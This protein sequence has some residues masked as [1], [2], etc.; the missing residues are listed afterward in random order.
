[1]SLLKIGTDSPSTL[2]LYSALFDALSKATFFISPE[3]LLIIPKNMVIPIRSQLVQSTLSPK[4]G[5]K[6]A[7][8]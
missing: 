7:I 3:I 8:P 5:I 4:P 6:E 2:R 1:M